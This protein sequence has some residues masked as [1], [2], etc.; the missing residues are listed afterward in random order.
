MESSFIRDEHSKALINN[1]VTHINARR[2]E[3]RQVQK[4]SELQA[5]I[6]EVK[7][8]LLEIKQLLH[9]FITRE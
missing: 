9:T 6:N 3:K 1:D 4:I 5:E 8:D 7:H 2:A